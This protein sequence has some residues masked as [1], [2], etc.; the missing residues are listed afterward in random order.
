MPGLNFMAGGSS[1]SATYIPPAVVN[2]NVTQSVGNEN[3]MHS[4]AVSELLLGTSLLSRN[5]RIAQLEHMLSEIQPLLKGEGKGNETD[6]SLS[7]E[8]MMGLTNATLL[9]QSTNN[10]WKIFRA[11]KKKKEGL[12]EGTPR[13]P[14]CTDAVVVPASV[15]V[16]NSNTTN[17]T[18]KATPPSVDDGGR[19]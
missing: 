18:T 6:D 1:A 17:N 4:S 12:C 10:L 15:V 19:G 9:K 8:A 16:S 7:E 5:N 11:L 13:E 14:A 3:V 2:E